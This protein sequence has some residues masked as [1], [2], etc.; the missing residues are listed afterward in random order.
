[1]DTPVYHYFLF[2][3]LYLL[4]ITRTENSLPF[5]SSNFGMPCRDGE[6]IQIKAP[7][8]GH[9]LY[10]HQGVSFEE[11]KEEPGSRQRSLLLLF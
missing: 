5:L 4:I 11:E 9:F 1:M 8:N 6:K 10:F 7:F 3:N 2:K